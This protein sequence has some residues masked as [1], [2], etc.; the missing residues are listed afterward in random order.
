VKAAWE[1]I[2]GA[3]RLSKGLAVAITGLCLAATPAAARGGF[4]GGGYRGGFGGAGVVRPFGYYGFYDP[5]IWGPSWYGG[6]YWG[7]GYSMPAGMGK[8]RIKT[9]LKDAEVFVDGAY[10]GTAGQTKDMFLDSGAHDIEVRAADHPKFAE[11]VYV[12]SGKTLNISP[13]F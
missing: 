10:A 2:L 8:I 4:H 6:S 3:K 5:W 13:G 12:L 11:R 1:A 9:Q 7:Y